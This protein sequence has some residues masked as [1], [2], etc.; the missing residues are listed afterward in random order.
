MLTFD[1]IETQYNRFYANFTLLSTNLNNGS[2]LLSNYI[3]KNEDFRLLKETVSNYYLKLINYQ[4]NKK[5]DLKQFLDIN[6][7]SH[8]DH[9]CIGRLSRR[10][11]YQRFQGIDAVLRQPSEKRLFSVNFSNHNPRADQNIDRPTD[12]QMSQT[13]FFCESYEHVD[14]GHFFPT[15]SFS[16]NRWIEKWWRDKIQVFGNR[17]GKLAVNSETKG[18]QEKRLLVSVRNFWNLQKVKSVISF[19]SGLMSSLYK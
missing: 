5:Y 9:C 18:N 11:S 19:V 3:A 4:E 16:W 1:R 14:R 17:K 7:A 15:D 8:R 13:I 10:I 2:V 6:L 12:F